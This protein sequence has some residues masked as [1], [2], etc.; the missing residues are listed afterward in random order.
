MTGMKILIA[1][2]ITALF[3]AA[4]PRGVRVGAFLQQVRTNFTVADGLPAEDVSA[5]AVAVDGSV[6]A[7]TS[8]GLARFAG[9]K[10]HAVAAFRGAPVEA[11]AARDTDVFVV[12]GGALWR[13]RQDQSVRLAALP[14]GVAARALSAD[15]GLLLATDAGLFEFARGRLLAVESLNRLLEAGRDV[16]QVAQARDGRAAAATSSGLFVRE[17]S[18]QWRRLYP[19]QGSRSWAPEDVRGVAFDSEGRLWFASVEG[20]G[21]Y[22]AGQWMLYTGYEGL[23]YDDFTCVAA[24]ERGVVWFGTRRGAIRFDGTNWE[25]RQ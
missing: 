6:F 3:A 9:G 25:Y 13:L 19:R 7:G 17:G 11:L 18:G 10:W 15:G 8:R 12:S 4:Q 24:G 20:A 14:Q 5:V 1:V 16:R 22:S 2:G 21:S 23:P